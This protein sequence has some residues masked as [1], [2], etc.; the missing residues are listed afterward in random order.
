VNYN[1]ALSF[2]KITQAQQR[3]IIAEI[4]RVQDFE[5]RYQMTRSSQLDLFFVAIHKVRP[6]IP[7]WALER[8]ANPEPL[9]KADRDLV[10]TM[11]AWVQYLEWLKKKRARD[12]AAKAAEAAAASRKGSKAART[13]RC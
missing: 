10:K 11:P 12:A 1:I 13:A 3:L 9:K 7:F 6:D 4:E 2:G 5:D 8:A